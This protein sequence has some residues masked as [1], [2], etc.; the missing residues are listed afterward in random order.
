MLMG[1]RVLC[2]KRGATTFFPGQEERLQAEDLLLLEGRP[3]DIRILQGLEELEI[4]RGTL[5]EMGALESARIGLVEAILSPRTVLAG[6]TL[7]QLNFR[8]KYGLSVIAIWREGRVY[9][10]NLR[11]MG[12][13]FGDALLL[14]GPRDRL[15]ML[16]KEP[17]FM[18]LTQ[19]AQEPPKTEKAWVS[20]LIMPA[21]IVPVIMGWVPIYIS[22]VVGAAVMVVTGC[23]TM[24]EAYRN[25]EWKAIF[26]IAGMLPLGIALERSG[27]ARILA[28]GVVSVVGPF[29]PVSVLLGLMLLTFAATCFI[30][31]AALVVL[32][33]PIAI[34]TAADMNLSPHALM[35]GIAM[36]ASASFM[37]PVSHPANLLVMGPG[38][39]RFVDYMKLGAPLSLVV[40]IVVLLVLPIFWPFSL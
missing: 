29:G 34:T 37:T 20:T 21:V 10:S 26:V 24:A 18:V 14:Y 38:G 33:A 39:Y 28:E 12:L 9:R 40:L 19:A 1:M 30:P 16:G 8:E 32:M 7:R 5:P 4:E 23:L 27:A 35:M 15:R 6:K 22:A 13:R 31:T 2:F 36:A 3:D 11:D 17:D 25:I